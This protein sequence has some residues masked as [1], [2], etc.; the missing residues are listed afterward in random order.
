V[1][2]PGCVRLKDKD[3]AWT[4]FAIDPIA[5]WLVGLARERPWVMPA[6]LTAGCAAIGVLAA[7]AF[8]SGREILGAL[9]FQVSFLLDCMDG[10]LAGVRDTHGPLGA[11]AD[12]AADIARLGLCATGLAVALTRDGRLVVDGVSYAAALV[13]L[14]LAARVAVAT[15]AAARPAL[16]MSEDARAPG[17]I[18]V[19]AT[20]WSILR[21]APRRSRL[22]G[23][24]VD[25]EAI[26]F[27]LGPLLGLPVEALVA[28]IAL[29]VA[30]AV[31]FGLR[32]R[33]RARH[34]K[35]G[36]NV[37]MVP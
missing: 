33:Y 26:V 15:I 35:R 34:E 29:D 12:V 3:A 19:R 24:T 7:V 37:T 32:A 28:A 5:A 16:A 21:V 8:A 31:A 23:T 25:T 27:T 18:E 14:Y 10:K 1:T 13:C 20:P 6:R 2:R 11:M 30:Y 17:Y 22:P 36:G 9:L 4:V